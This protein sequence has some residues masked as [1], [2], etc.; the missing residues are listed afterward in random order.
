MKLSSPLSHILVGLVP[1]VLDPHLSWFKMQ[2]F[3]EIADSL[4]FMKTQS[5]KDSPLRPAG[6]T[7]WQSWG[8][9]RQSPCASPQWGTPRRTSTGWTQTRQASIR[10]EGDTRLKIFWQCESQKVIISGGILQTFTDTANEN[11]NSNDNDCKNGNVND[12]DNANFKV[13]IVWHHCWKLM[14]NVAN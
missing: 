1:I 6:W 5:L 4:V 3:T 10:V 13:L 7:G 14:K 12:N 9:R 2:S 11:H 8:Q